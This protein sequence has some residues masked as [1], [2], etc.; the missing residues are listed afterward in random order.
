MFKFR[1]D[2][3]KRLREYTEK[4]CQ[5]EVVRC[6]NAL[7]LAQEQQQFLENRIKETEGDIARL[8]EG[9]LD[10]SRLIL[11]QDYLTYL[12]E[13]LELQKAVVAEKKEEL[14]VARSKLMEAMKKRKILAKLEEKQYQQYLYLQDKKEQALLDELASR[15][16]M[17]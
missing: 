15:R 1:L 11:Y 5:D 12:Q 13:Q 8:Q 10:I 14:R 3:I 9:V 4:Q 16:S 2:S 7:R 17:A 6:L